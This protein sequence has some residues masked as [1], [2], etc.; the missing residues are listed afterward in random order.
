MRLLLSTP[1][2]LYTAIIWSKIS[3][4]C[5]SWYTLLLVSAI[6]VATGFI[7]HPQ[8]CLP[9]LTVSNATVPQPQKISATVLTDILYSSAL[10]IAF[11]VIN[12]GNLAGY[13]C[14][15]CI[16]LSRSAGIFHSSLTLIVSK[17]R[18]R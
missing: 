12:A 16:R 18:E 14:I 6:N 10:W 8:K 11:V 3:F 15:L 5:L 13:A 2:V 7:S 1:L 9:L 4:N 17:S